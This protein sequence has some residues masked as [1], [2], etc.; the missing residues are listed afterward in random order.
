MEDRRDRLTEE[1]GSFTVEAAF[2]VSLTLFAILTAVL[3]AFY[4]RDICT[5]AARI[6]LDSLGTAVTEIGGGTERVFTL[7]KGSLK[8]GSGTE[9]ASLRMAGFWPLSG[10]HYTETIRRKETD[11]VQRL[12]T[13]RQEGLRQ[14]ADQKND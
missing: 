7:T 10:L 9:T 12:R 4:L 3:M 11:P 5:A 14:H 13:L 6:R 2:V 8:G 1:K